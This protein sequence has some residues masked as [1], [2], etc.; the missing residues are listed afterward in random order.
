M[1]LNDWQ[2]E[3]ILYNNINN[4]CLWL[5]KAKPY[6][7]MFAYMGMLQQSDNEQPTNFNLFTVIILLGTERADFESIIMAEGPVSRNSQYM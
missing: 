7:T 5:K 6:M 2:E 1:T 4:V 3:T